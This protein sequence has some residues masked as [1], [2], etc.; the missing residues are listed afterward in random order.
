MR[1]VRI[2][3]LSDFHLTK[4]PG[5]N[6]EGIDPREALRLMLTACAHVD[7]VD[8]VVVSGDIADDGSSDAYAARDPRRGSIAYEL[9]AGELAEMIADQGPPAP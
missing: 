1:A 8:M 9:D 6:A 2:L 3:H 5:P 7:A 4:L